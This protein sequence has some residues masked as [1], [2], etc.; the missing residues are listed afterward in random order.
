MIAILQGKKWMGT[1]PAVSLE[2]IGLLQLFRSLP[3]DAL[4][5]VRDAMRIER[6]ARD[7][8]I[9]RQGNWVDRAYAL[10]AGSV[11]IVQTGSDGGQAIVRFIGPGEMFGT[12][13]LFTDHRFPADA[14]A[15]EAST[16]L[17]WPETDLLALMARYPGISYNVIGVLG[18]RMAQLQERLRELTTQR[19]EQRVAH[20]IVR[21]AEQAGRDG[22]R[23]TTI[24][25]PLRRK[26]LAEFAGTTLHT[27]SRTVSAW[28]KAGLL[29]TD[30]QRLVIH[31]LAAIRTLAEGCRA[32]F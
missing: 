25:I 22:T 3:V 12:L 26:D 1:D 7:A 29:V 16:V 28:E 31:D 30:G 4:E 9:F 6:I 27:A 24:E 14:I 11:R 20:A 32:M 5:D 8:T 18:A 2:R 19:V 21:L 10:G 23:G 15:V 13:P 17:T